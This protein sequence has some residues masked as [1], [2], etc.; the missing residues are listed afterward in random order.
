MPVPARLAAAASAA[1]LAAVPAA[2]VANGKPGPAPAV[3][4]PIATGLAGPLQLA[5]DGGDVHVT[6]QFAGL[7]T[8]FGADGTR[9]D[10]PVADI[11]GIEARHG[12]V[13]YATRAGEEAEVTASALSRLNADGTTAPVADLLAYERRAN[14]D[15]VNTYGFASIPA[16]CAA[17]LPPELGPP[18]STGQIDSNP[19]A[20]LVRHGRTY[21]ADAG[22]NAILE[23]T[24]KGVRTVAVLPPQPAVVTQAAA[25]ELKLPTCAVGLTYNFEPVPT[26][27]EAGPGHGLYVTTLP[28]GPESPVLGPRGAVHRIDTRTGHVR[29]I[30][31][32]FL[33]ATG[34]AVGPEGTLYVAELFA[35]RVSTPGPKGPVPVAELPSPSALE[36]ARGKL[37]VTYDVFENGSVAT[38]APVRR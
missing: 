21:V 37:Y 4:P 3:S 26:D 19:F 31:R 22:A 13:T 9:T 35:G 7:L 29:T 28:G 16:D 23:V 20:V 33:G 18:S 2:A 36:Y 11:A 5:V 25:D 10:T 27:V 14:P 12:A 30:A 24:R 6:Q 32:G 34:L 15:A 8:R 1:L 17:Q 38:I